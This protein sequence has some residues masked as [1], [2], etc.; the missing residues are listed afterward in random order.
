MDYGKLRAAALQD[1]EDEEA[2]TVDTRALIDKVLARYS[3]EWTTL[4]ELIQNAADAQAT[5]IKVKW[6]TLPSTQVPLPAVDD[7]S[8]ILKHI[9]TNHTLRRLVVQNDGQPFT[10]TDWARLKR[11]AEGNPDETK[12]GAFGVG[13]YSVFADCEEPFISS[14]GEAMA[15]YWK[16]N[17]LFTRKV[18]LSA[19]MSSPDTAFVLDYRNTTTTVPNLLSVGQ[20]LATSLT[21]VALQHIEFWIDDYQILSL[22]KKASPSAAVT[23]PRDMDM[24]TREGLMKVR[25]VDRSSAQIDASYMNAI[26]WKPQTAAAKSETYGMGAPEVNSLRSF[27]SRL[28]ANAPKVS[29]AAREEKAV[30]DTISEN[31]TRLSTSTIFLRVTTGSIATSIKASFASE[32]ERATKKPPPKLTKL[33]ILTSSYDE[34]QAS[35]ST[36]ESDPVSAATDVFA[37]V[38]PSKKGGRIFIGFPTTQTTG[39]GMHISAPSVIPTVER[40]AIDLNARWV[41][42]WNMEMLRAAGI[43]T[44]LAFV[45]EMNE[46]QNK[47]QRATGNTI[48]AKDSAVFIP[49]ALHIMKAFTFSDS[50]PSAH[51]SQIIEEA[52][53]TA[54]KKPYVEIF[55]TRGV[56]PTTQV[57]LGSQELEKFVGDIAVVPPELETVGFVRKLIE[58]DLLSHITVEDVRKEL[59]AKPLTEVQ[60]PNFIQ[61]IAKKTLRGDLDP[62]SRDQLLDVAVAIVNKKSENDQGD[63]IAL[64]SIQHFMG[65][66]K[67]PLDLPLPPTTIP[68]EFTKACS[69]QEL[70]ALSWDPLNLAPWITFVIETRCSRSP[71]QDMTKS[72]DFAIRILSM[73]SKSW[74]NQSPSSKEKIASLLKA[75]TIMPTKL[76]MRRPTESFFPSVKLFD[77]LPVIECTQLKDKFLSAL[78]VRKTLDLETIFKRL[79]N[80]S[81]KG[82][83]GEAQWSHVELIK[84]LASVREDIPSDDMRR[85]RESRICPAEAGPADKRSSQSSHPHYSKVSDLFEPNRILRPL[86]L[87]ILQWPG[88]VL[89]RP[90]PEGQFLVELGLRTHPSVAELVDM[91]SSTD[92]D[93]RRLSMSYYVTHFTLH[94]YRSYNMAACPRAF[95]PIEGDPDRLVSPSGCFT[96]EA[97]A[98]L[99]FSIL[100][101]I[102]HSEAQ[103]FGVAR[104]PPIQECVQRLI[105]NPPESQRDAMIV[106][107]Y[108]SSRINDLSSTA[109]KSLGSTRIVPVRRRTR[110]SGYFSSNDADEKLGPISHLT[111]RQ[112]YLGSSAVY[113]EIF[114]FV[115]FGHSANAFLKACGS[116]DEPTKLEIAQRAATEPARL[117]SVLGSPDKYLN[118]L[119]SLAGDMAV[120]K[121]DKVLWKTMKTSPFLLAF[122]E[123][124]NPS[125]SKSIDADEDE[126]AVRTYQLGRPSDIVILDDI[127]SYRLFKDHLKCAP[128]EDQLESFYG[129]LGSPTLSTVVQEDLKL[130]S[131]SEKQDGAVWLR[132]H[133]LERSK[134]FIHE[135]AK[136]SRDVIKHDAKWLEQNLGV[137]VVRSVSLRRTLRVSGQSHVEKRS[138]AISQT[139]A[140]WVLFVDSESSRPDMYQVGQAICQLILNRPSQ[141]AYLQ[142]EPFLKL[143]LLDLRA[144]G[145]N[146]DRILRA[147][148]AEARIAEEERRKALEAEQ[149]RIRE[150]EQEFTRQNQAAAATAAAAA[151]EQN[152]T[153]PPRMPGGFDSPDE[154]NSPPPTPQ[155]PQRRGRGLLSN[156]S[157]RFGFDV[158]EPEEK[159]KSLTGAEHHPEPL[160]PT[161]ASPSGSKPIKDGQ[162]HDGKVTNP[163]IVH[164]NLLNAIKSTRAYDSSQLYSPP[165]TSTVKEQATYCDD[166][167]A[168]DLSLLAD[169]SNGM[170]VFVSNSIP[171]ATKENFVSENHRAINAF[172]SLLKD[173]GDI[174]KIP[175]RVLHI[176][177]DEQGGTIAFNREGSI[178]CNLRFYNQLHRDQ[179]TPEGMAEASVWWWVVLAHELAHNIIHPHNA[180]HS[181]YTE[182]FIQQYFPLMMMRATAIMGEPPAQE[183]QAQAL[184]PAGLQQPL[185]PERRDTNSRASGP[186]PPYRAT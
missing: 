68:L 141:Q 97:S 8:E 94:D 81:E 54:Y 122:K 114:D 27:F 154:S 127:I 91:M 139:R 33:S 83:S 148:A 138:A 171:D 142:F 31:I 1:G 35:G 129:A 82:S 73:I 85:L 102:L 125:K 9:I 157:R 10:K 132:K 103:K 165:S 47:L 152:R 80:P 44:R 117:L 21:F 150:Q 184:P 99:G 58:F 67:I 5:T 34:T 105:K 38:L 168:K 120:L 123:I 126:E 92:E 71:D 45:H 130:G 51:V 24:A 4:R 16:G 159:P 95:L 164:Q 110:A 15:F 108:F 116:N 155:P 59:A 19:A 93:L 57:R 79:M 7:R 124:T 50:T 60:L 145:Y 42:N 174:Y 115:D 18:Q 100:S 175:R 137:E 140:G 179:T 61:W 134:I 151:R 172:A 26:G 90:S 176:F 69:L 55:S 98:V 162:G 53:W 72:P 86:G 173:V 37:S 25:T 96:N 135:Y 70:Q 107:Q 113:G 178:F 52:F 64:G 170:R 169:A 6:E 74:E 13:F 62:T 23:I 166:T 63:I 66:L 28:T 43:L 36:K 104:D 49:E 111:P 181:Y 112:C 40:E 56:L 32:L 183:A 11:I 131:H 182:S 128:E 158:D 149:E 77:D 146:V 136:Y 17:A 65:T 160:P 3:G 180:D 2:V 143:N 78:G 186:P 14:G 119:R 84:Y 144:R 185:V 12:I 87:K 101:R 161:T 121:R 109:A 75:H 118:L 41:R 177:Y 46:L 48:T 88:G 163:A 30:Q 76:G 39:G 29:K 167:A 106:F 153:P 89:N 133:V 147:K 20:F 156:I 22:Q